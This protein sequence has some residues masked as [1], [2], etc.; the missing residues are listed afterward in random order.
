MTPRLLLA[1]LLLAAP[2]AA[3]E[4]FS[5]ALPSQAEGATASS[6]GCFSDPLKLTADSYDITLSAGSVVSV[7]SGKSDV[8]Y[9][10]QVKGGGPLPLG[11]YRGLR[12]DL[13]GNLGL[14]SSAGTIETPENYQSIGLQGELSQRISS[15]WVAEDGLVSFTSLYVGVGSVGLV[16]KLSNPSLYTSASYAEAGLNVRWLRNGKTVALV[17]AALGQDQR[18]NGDWQVAASLRASARLPIS[19]LKSVDPRIHIKA[20]RGLVDYGRGA[21][22][23]MQASLT[24]GWSG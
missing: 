22:N 7:T 24:V 18:L 5:S 10:A 14:S 8:G 19:K 20:L 3:Q 15:R 13:E 6:Q 4:P 2:A 1:L 21:D 9:E 23:V 17:S 11:C 12:L 16:K